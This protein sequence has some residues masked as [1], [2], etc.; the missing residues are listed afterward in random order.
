LPFL[1]YVNL[2]KPARDL[3]RALASGSGPVNGVFSPGG[4][5]IQKCTGK[6]I[7]AA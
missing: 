4:C 7:E 1:R 2:N 3:A 5:E 6:A